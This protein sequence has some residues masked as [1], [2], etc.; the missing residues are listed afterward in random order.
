MIYISGDT[1]G[2]FER[3]TNEDGRGLRMSN[4]MREPNK[5]WERG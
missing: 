4:H 1:H 3:I 2:R 5:P